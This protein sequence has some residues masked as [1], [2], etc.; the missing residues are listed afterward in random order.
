MKYK[1]DDWL[2]GAGGKVKSGVMG[3]RRGVYS[4]DDEIVLESV[5]MFA[6][7]YECIKSHSGIHFKTESYGI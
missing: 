1:A 5:R 4:G 7:S 6:Q 2:P 3:Q